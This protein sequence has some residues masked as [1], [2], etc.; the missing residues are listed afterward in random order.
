MDKQVVYLAWS[1]QGEH[2]LGAHASTDGVLE[3]LRKEAVDLG[4]DP[5]DVNGEPG[6]VSGQLDGLYYSAHR[7]R[8]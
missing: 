5:E 7:L 6:G 4:M 1:F 8:P 2:V 3:A